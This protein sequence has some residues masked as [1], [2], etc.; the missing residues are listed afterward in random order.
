MMTT[1]LQEDRLTG[2]IIRKGEIPIIQEMTILLPEGPTPLMFI[3]GPKCLQ[4]IQGLLE[5]PAHLREV[6]VR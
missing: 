6:Q 5:A 3:Q 2:L 4:E 1:V